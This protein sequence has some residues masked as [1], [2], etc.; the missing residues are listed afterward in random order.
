MQESM[1][2][3]VRVG[4]RIAERAVLHHALDEVDRW[5]LGQELAGWCVVEV[6]P[7]DAVPPTRVEVTR[8]DDWPSLERAG[9]VRRLLARAVVPAVAVVY[10]WSLTDDERDALEAAGYAVAQTVAEAAALV[11]ARAKP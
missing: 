7:R 4:G 1:L 9:H 11:R 3:Q 2:R 10:G 6:E 5:E 8:A